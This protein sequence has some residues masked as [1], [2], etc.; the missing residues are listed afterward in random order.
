MV[1]INDRG[2]F[3]RGRIIDLSYAAAKVIGMV[4]PGVVPVRIE[5]VT[6]I[7]PPKS[8][9]RYY[10]QVGAFIYKENA[11]TLKQRLRNKFRSVYISTFKT[12]QQVYYRVR[13]KAKDAKS[14]NRIAQRLLEEGYN[15]IIFEEN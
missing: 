10:L 9:Q 13:I 5:V 8:S 6:G 14:A 11:E 2:P 4:G 7:S 1:R 12:L 3:V 15:V